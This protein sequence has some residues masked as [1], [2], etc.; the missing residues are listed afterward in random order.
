MTGQHLRWHHGTR[1]AD[2][3]LGQPHATKMCTALESRNAALARVPG[4]PGRGR[5]P[6]V[7]RQRRPIV[8][9]HPIST[10]TWFMECLREKNIH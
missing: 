3:A 10:M 6:G 7:A 8:F 4:P 5:R 9:D 2:V 1:P